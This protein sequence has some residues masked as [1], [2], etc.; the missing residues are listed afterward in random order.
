MRL[1]NVQPSSPE[2]PTK[3]PFLPSTQN[4]TS[5]KLWRE[6]CLWK[7]GENGTSWHDDSGRRRSTAT[8][9]PHTQRRWVKTS[10]NK[11][12]NRSAS[13]KL[14]NIITISCNM[15]IFCLSGDAA[16]VKNTN[17]NET[18][19]DPPAIA[20]IVRNRAD[21]PD[22][23]NSNSSMDHALTFPPGGAV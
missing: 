15:I 10:G 12:Y 1:K 5:A 22:F 6:V 8:M 16:R 4:G 11:V 20:A 18:R 17:K 3:S 2:N 19:I 13:L 7:N 23:R 14:M 21:T 9:V